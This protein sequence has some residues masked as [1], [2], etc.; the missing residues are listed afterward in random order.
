MPVAL[1][2]SKAEQVRRLLSST[3]YTPRAIASLVGCS[4]QLVTRERLK[5]RCAS[6]VSTRVAFQSGVLQR[7]RDL[8][9][10]VNALAA[11]V[12]EMKLAC[13]VLRSA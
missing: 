4:Y 13:S 6:G 3:N 1:H 10:Y 7:L 11:Q 5:T 2:P 9:S 8:E 12:E